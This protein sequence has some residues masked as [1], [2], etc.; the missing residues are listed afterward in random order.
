MPDRNLPFDHAVITF[1]YIDHIEENDEVIGYRPQ[2]RPL[3]TLLKSIGSW[4][5]LSSQQAVGTAL[6]EHAITADQGAFSKDRN[7]LTERNKRG[8]IRFENILSAGSQI[9]R[10]EADFFHAAFRWAF[11]DAWAEKIPAEEFI[12]LSP[13]DLIAKGTALDLPWPDLPNPAMTIETMLTGF[14]DGR[15]K[16][17]VLRKGGKRVGLPEGSLLWDVIQQPDIEVLHPGD[18]FELEVSGIRPGIEQ[19]VVFSLCHEPIPDEDTGASYPVFLSAWINAPTAVQIVTPDSSGFRVVPRL[20]QYAWV[21]IVV[22]QSWELQERL[23][24]RRRREALT[25]E[26]AGA[27]LVRLNKMCSQAPKAVRS[28]VVSY[29]IAPRECC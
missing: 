15:L 19:L 17:S 28:D 25:L 24:L 7:N 29:F 9:S 1:D 16:L 22:P 18:V 5:S 26:A 10:K 2:L 13:R 11:G 8:V 4:S 3:F 21:A 20:G 6:Y 14:A 27:L 12:Q 23:E